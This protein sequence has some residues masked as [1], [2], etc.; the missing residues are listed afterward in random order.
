MRSHKPIGL[1]VEAEEP[2]F[3]STREA[4]EAYME[5]IDVQDGI[6]SAAYDQYG[7]TYS[8]DILD[9]KV[10]IDTSAGNENAEAKLRDILFQFLHEVNVD[11][12]SEDA[13]SD[14]IEKC[15]PYVVD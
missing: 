9:D 15:R 8:I 11:T 3:F 6:Y 10:V 4:A 2:V 14:L 7:N 13:T 12:S 5:P 1:I